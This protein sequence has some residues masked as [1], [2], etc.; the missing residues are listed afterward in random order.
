MTSPNGDALKIDAS[1]TKDFFIFMLIKDVDL[2]P[3]IIDLVDNSLDGARRLRPREKDNYKG[4][5]IAV[6]TKATHFEITDN[7]GGIDVETAKTYAFRF[8][9]PPGMPATPRSVGQFGVGMKRALFKLGTAFRIESATKTS[10]FSMAVNVDDW[11]KA[12][13]E[14]DFRFSEE[15]RTGIKVA[16]SEVGTVV[17]VKPLHASVAEEFQSPTFGSRLVEEIEKAH[18]QNILRGLDISVNGR[19]LS[20]AE[21]DLLTSNSL[22]P[23]F[24]RLPLMSKEHG[25]VAVRLYAG[26]SKSDPSDAGWYVYCNDRLVLKADQTNTTG[27]GEK[28]TPRIP[29]FHNQFADFRGYVFFEADDSAGLPWNTSKTDVEL[30]HPAFRSTRV[31]MVQMMRPVIDFLNKVKEEGEGRPQRDPGP[32]TRTLRGAKPTKLSKLTT[33]GHF[34]YKPARAVARPPGSA[35]IQYFR[36]VAQIDRVKDT[37]KVD[38]NREVGERTF[39]YYFKTV[40]SS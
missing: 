19:S 21:P 6:T 14:W 36:P 7:C 10:R 20:S 35:S 3:A 8:G 16:A 9:R 1:P 5:R 18:S 30:E 11:R 24:E 13:R 26:V 15:P 31:R 29:Q 2:I 27:W 33:V 25:P 22:T 38:S 4:L 32:F 28:G 17:R 23:G 37:L 40:I 34:K 12:E 39:D